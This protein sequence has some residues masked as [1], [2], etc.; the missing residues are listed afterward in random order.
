MPPTYSLLGDYF[1]QSSQRVK[2]MSVYLLSGPFAILISFGV[3]GW[4]NSYYGWRVAFFVMGVPG[5]LMALL[6]RATL[7]DPRSVAS[8]SPSPPR[9]GEILRVL[10]QR[11]STRHLAAAIV[12]LYTLGY[13]MAPWYGAFLM[14]SHAMTT[15]QV[16]LWMGVILSGAGIVGVV[17]G[18]VIA[19]RWLPDNERSQMQL[20][21]ITIAALV[22]LYA[23]F[24]LA[25]QRL[26]S[27]VA[28]VPLVTVFNIFSAPAF[29]LIQ[30]LVRDDMR[31]TTLALV[32]L[33][34]NLIGMGLGPQLVGIMSDA[35]APRFGP[36][37]LRY[38]ML[39]TSL[40]ALVAS[41][42]FWRVGKTVAA[43]LA[44]TG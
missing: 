29:S 41:Y 44:L 32:M 30:R 34:V 15:Q 27:L 8:T 20:S 1:P 5:L 17:M 22:P 40:L 43:D 23:A 7:T 33:L 6:V 16:G 35:L 38:A 13:G 11:R 26:W 37:S 12:V 18:G 31:A 9:F 10:W 25:P 14:R 42:E 28:F 19:T 2:A 3:G 24:L 4:V 39:V 36:D 21:A